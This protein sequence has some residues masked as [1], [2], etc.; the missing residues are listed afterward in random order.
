MGANENSHKKVLGIVGSPRHG[1]NTDILV[2]EIL[3]GAGEAGAE[4]VKVS[5]NKLNIAPCM[6]CDVC[7]RTGKCAQRDDMQSLVEKMDS[8]QVMVL[9][10]PLYWYGPSAQIKTFIDRWYGATHEMTF[11]GRRVILAI[12]W[13][14]PDPHAARHLEGMFK[15]VL[16]FLNIEHFAT[17][18]APGVFQQGD[19]LEH[20]AVLEE[21][22]RVGREVINESSVVGQN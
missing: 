10:T 11:E 8:S 13:G 14:Q 19:V 15:E 18:L 6:A 12:A 9:G 2:D 5:L 3:R 20:S 7:G 22:Q 17:V 16:D 4:V 21:A 1:G